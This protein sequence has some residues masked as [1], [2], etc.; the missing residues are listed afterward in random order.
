MH[1]LLAT[2]D[3]KT[4]TVPEYLDLVNEL[5]GPLKVFVEGEITDLK[6]LPQWTFFSLKDAESG[7]LL[8]CGLH[9]GVY[10]RIGVR[11]EEGM[12]I[13]VE[14][15]GKISPKTGNF[16]FWVSKI[17]PVGEGALKRSYEL[18]V[19]KMRE[20]GLFDRKRT[21][22]SFISHI[23]VISSRN[24]VVIQDLRNNLARLGIRIDFLHSGVE[25][26]DS[27]RD[28]LRAIEHFSHAVDR[29]QVLILIRGGGSLES[30]Q[31]FNNEA[32]CRALYAA[33]MPVL[34]G[35]GHDVDAPIATMIADWSASTPTAVAHVIN[36]SWAAITERVPLLAQGMRGRFLYRI[37]SV[38]ARVPLLVRRQHERFVRRVRAVTHQADLTVR[39]MRYAI[40]QLIT[41][42]GRYE[43]SL[44]RARRRIP[45]RIEHLRK[46]ST[47][48]GTSLTEVLQDRLQS[49]MRAVEGGARLLSASDPERVLSRGYSLVY[50]QG[51]LVRSVRDVSVGSV[52]TTTLHDGTVQSVT[53]EVL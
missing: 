11:V 29:P 31:G 51:T 3:E 49:L 47:V 2:L 1:P 18:L 6:I 9:S 39:T 34:V 37:G 19:Q 15:Y 42:F 52:L 44:I 24:G 38:G 30:L 8:R 5:M 23:G 16:G 13:K 4:L 32:V 50:H 43:D 35:I 22:P 20:E 26:A 12:T 33:P 48:L 53:Q 7:A 36:A 14:G 45:V 21:L 17:E 41:R 10:R 28:I 25:G 46:Q 40:S 27:A